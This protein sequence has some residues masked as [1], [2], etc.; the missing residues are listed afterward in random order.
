MD[1]AH[2]ASELTDGEWTLFEQLHTHIDPVGRKQTRSMRRI[3]EAAFHTLGAFST[4]DRI[5]K[6]AWGYL[7]QLE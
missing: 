5:H 4:S 6:P 1:A 7:A 2:D 3:V